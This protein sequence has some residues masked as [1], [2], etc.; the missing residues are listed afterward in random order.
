MHNGALCGGNGSDSNDDDGG[1]IK[2]KQPTG[3]KRRYKTILNQ[4]VWLLW[5]TLI[6]L[7]Y[8]LFGDFIQRNNAHRKSEKL[9]TVFDKF[10]G[11]KQKAYT[12][13]IFFSFEEINNVHFSFFILVFCFL[14]FFSWHLLSTSM[15]TLKRIERQNTYRAC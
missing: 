12:E 8:S 15:I 4:C 13:K 3:P 5:W 10:D 7:I 11:H 9:P 2:D 1:K 6:T 14:C